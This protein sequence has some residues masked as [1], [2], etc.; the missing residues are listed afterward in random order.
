MNKLQWNCDR[1]S[2]IFIQENV[3]ENVVCEMADILSRHQC[4]N[5][6]AWFLIIG[7]P[8]NQEYRRAHLQPDV[9][10]RRPLAFRRLGDTGGVWCPPGRRHDWQHPC[11]T[12]G[13]RK[14]RGIRPQWVC[15]TGSGL[16]I[17]LC[18]YM[19]FPVLTQEAWWLFI[20]WGDSNSK[21][22]CDVYSNDTFVYIYNI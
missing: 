13:L 10:L 2:Y 21:N 9:L 14:H 11:Q 6:F 3:F 1:N 15:R 16:L 19:R 12:P 18:K 22:I 7:V 5:W 20:A 17:P 8:Q 4:V